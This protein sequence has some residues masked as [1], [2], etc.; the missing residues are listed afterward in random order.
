MLKVVIA[1]AVIALLS[2]GALLVWSMSTDDGWISIGVNALLVLAVGF[3]LL[4]W[5]L[6]WAG[7]LIASSRRSESLKPS[8]SSPPTNADRS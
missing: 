6:V 2:G 5:G 1:A 4:V 7:A 3:V 8:A